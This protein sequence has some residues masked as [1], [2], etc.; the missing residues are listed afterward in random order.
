MQVHVTERIASGSRFVAPRLLEQLAA[1][2]DESSDPPVLDAAG[3]RV[4][5][6][7]EVG[8]HIGSP[9][10]GARIRLSAKDHA[11]RYPVFEG[12]LRIEPITALDSTLLLEGEYEVPLGLIGRLADRTVL[13]TTAEGSLARLMAQMKST[14]SAAILESVTGTPP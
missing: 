4:P 2:H 14:L 6:S 7:V 3:I 11:G 13:R 12:T 10:N 8:E 1:Y 9:P 5:I